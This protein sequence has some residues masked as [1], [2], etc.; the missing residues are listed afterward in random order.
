MSLLLVSRESR[1]GIIR[2]NR[3]EA[4]NALSTELIE[5]LLAAMKEFEHDATIGSIVLTGTEKFFSAGAD[6]K[7][8]GALDFITAYKSD[9]FRNLNDQISSIR[10][11]IVAAV[12]GFA[13]GGGCELAMLCDII[14]AGE[15]AS[16]G[17]P[18][19]KIG[20]IPGIGGTQRLIRA[21]GKAKAMELILTGG[22]ISAQEAERC[23][24]VARVLP[25]AQ[26]L[27][28]AIQTAQT[29]ASYSSPITMMAKEAIQQA[30]ELS[31]QEGIRAE[32]RLYLSTFATADLKEG[33]S[34]FIEK[35]RPDFKNC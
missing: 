2:L 24:L 28:A 12:N 17:L 31:L 34:A 22:S 20:T 27:E 23:G 26:V 19:I 21:I 33:M 11:P 10:K 16:F 18:E 13:L 9:L 4:R 5:Q 25:P 29:I 7:Q 6:I 15:T 1:V 14:Y 32:R 8:L 30:E 3:P 35:R